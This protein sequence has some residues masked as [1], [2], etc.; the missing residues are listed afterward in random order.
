VLEWLAL[1]NWLTMLP[2]GTLEGKWGHVIQLQG[3]TAD[4]ARVVSQKTLPEPY[5]VHHMAKQAKK[6][7]AAGAR[8]CSL[9]RGFGAQEQAGRS[10]CWA[11]S[12]GCSR[13]ETGGGSQLLQMSASPS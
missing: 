13:R 6:A 11:G 3:A 5:G 4:W 7:H 2:A 12:P 9:G 8:Q 1:E 10:Q